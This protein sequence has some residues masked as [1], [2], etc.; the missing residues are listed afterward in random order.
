MASQEQELRNK[1]LMEQMEQALGHAGIPKFEMQQMLRQ[2]TKAL[3]CNAD[4]QKK[5]KLEK[6]KTT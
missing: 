6:L 4:C 5:R 3:E 1:L 2:A